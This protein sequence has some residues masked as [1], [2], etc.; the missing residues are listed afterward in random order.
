MWPE[1]QKLWGLSDIFSIVMVTN[2]SVIYFATL[3]LKKENLCQ[4]FRLIHS[5]HFKTILSHNLY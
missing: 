4:S 5:I 1:P 3:G 2:L